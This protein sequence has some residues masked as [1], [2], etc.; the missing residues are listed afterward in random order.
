MCDTAVRM[1]PYSLISV[2]DRFKTQKMRDKAVREERF[3]LQCVPDWFVT[4]QQIGPWC[5][6][7]ILIKWYEGFK[8]R[9]VQKTQIKEKRLPIAWDG[10]CQEVVEVTDNR[11]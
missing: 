6:D 2:P 3:S 10:V 4:Q 8:K 11:F 7:N 9:K 5:D 1:E